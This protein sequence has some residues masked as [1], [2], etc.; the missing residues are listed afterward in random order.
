MKDKH[1]G[2]WTIK[3]DL[4]KL[5][6]VSVDGY[7]DFKITWLSDNE[8]TITCTSSGWE[9][10]KSWTLTNKAT[11]EKWMQPEQIATMEAPE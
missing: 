10:M 4:I 8:F 9:F 1:H 5:K 11:L 2:T 6:W 7:A 3:N